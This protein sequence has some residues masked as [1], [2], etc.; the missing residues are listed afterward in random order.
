MAELGQL[1]EFPI[2]EAYDNQRTKEGSS[3]H[4]L[5]HDRRNWEGNY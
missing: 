2:P 3:P 5:G 4:P 1:Y